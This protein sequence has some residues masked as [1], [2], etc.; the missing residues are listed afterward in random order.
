MYLYKIRIIVILLCLLPFGS[1]A[2]TTTVTMIGTVT[3]DQTGE[4]LPFANVYLN[5]SSIG[6]TTDEQGR[7]TLTN[8][9]VGNLDMAVS[10]LGYAPIKHTLRFEMPGTVKVLFKMRQG[11]E[12]EKLVVFSKKGR[13]WKQRLKTVSRELLGTGRFARACRLL[14]PEV[15]RIWEDEDGHLLAESVSPLQ[16]ENRALGY[17]IYQDL[18]D[19]DYYRTI[20]YYGGNTRFELL[21]PETTAEKTR[22]RANRIEAYQSSLK[23]LLTSMVSDSL[24]ENGFRVFQE[25]P[26]SLRVA[27]SDS[28]ASY[29]PHSIKKHLNTRIKEVEGANLI[30]AG[31]L[32]TERRI[33][34]ATKLEVFDL[35]KR[36]HSRYSDMP[37]AQ[38]VIHLPQGYA[39]I[40]LQGWLV[41]PMGIEIG[42]DLAS[43]RFA[44][45]LPAD[46]VRE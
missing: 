20:M 21:E 36:A 16:I 35:N 9:P 8:L 7:Y 12:L 6:T 32:A 27:S 34:S 22:W 13:K 30:Q 38:S 28:G 3:D 1:P 42:G 29:P 5:N 18:S 15:L 40:T 37:Y 44:T 45:L 43:N 11:M 31:K 24:H 23:H 2:Q 17:L 25:I 4:P 10:Y 19:F 39:V 14:N 41:V 33:V 46:W 26:D